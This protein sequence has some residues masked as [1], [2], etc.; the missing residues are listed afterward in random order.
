MRWFALFLM[1]S[2]CGATN[3]KAEAEPTRAA[4]AKPAV[5]PAPTP[6]PAPAPPAPPI[7]DEPPPGGHDFTPTG[8]IILSVGACGG[9][10]T[11]PE[12]FRK[13]L[14]SQHCAVIEKTQTQYKKAWLDV[15]APFF[16]AHVPATVPKQV[17]YPF[18]GGDLST[19]LTVYPDAD[20]ITTMSLEPA[21]D[22][23]TLE[24]LAKQKSPSLD[25]GKMT[26]PESVKPAPLPTKR[27]RSPAVGKSDKPERSDDGNADEEPVVLE[28]GP[29]TLEKALRTVEYELRF[30]YRVNFSN[31]INMIDA[32]RG[33][34]LP[35]NL[36]FSLSAL[37]VHGYE[38][39]SLRYFKLDAEGNIKYL[40]DDDVASAPNPTTG[41]P[42][43][44]NRIFANAEI[45]FKRPGGRVQIYRHIQVNLDNDHLKKDMRVIKHL[46]LKGNVAGMTKAASYL[47]S[48]DSFSI[49]RG[50]LIGNVQWMVSDATGVA[51]KWGKP[52]GF[53]YETY[54]AFQIPHIGAG[55]SIAKDWRDEFAR[56]P[57]RKLGFRFGYYDG[58]KAHTNHLIIMHK[59]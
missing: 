32:M 17:V 11:A 14:I 35:T 44:R 49:I 42:D 57:T 22:P 54:G 4:P 39:V 51:P 56:E 1:V 26:K 25:V 34:L 21:G 23:R 20:E 28:K 5:T 43:Y 55:N 9:D 18:A 30:L 15:A 38:V 8:K 19:A 52:K 45:R 7:G 29:P 6:T 46:E 31:T 41:A 27:K 36:I 37:K 47:L 40:T 16:V 2:A 33:G 13:E 59:P 58:T 53:A 48:W 50:Y 3:D 10:G 24:A 12:G